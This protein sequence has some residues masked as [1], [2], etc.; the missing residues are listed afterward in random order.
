MSHMTNLPEHP[1]RFESRRSP[2]LS[3][4][5]IVA[6]SQPLASL[7]GLRILREGGNAADAAVA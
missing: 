5:G 6:S 3:R 7:A 1:F 4:K 2:V